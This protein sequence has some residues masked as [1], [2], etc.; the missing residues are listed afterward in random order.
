[1]KGIHRPDVI[2]INRFWSQEVLSWP[3]MLF[4][5]LDLGF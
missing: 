1:M 3:E 5:G 4:A 2:R